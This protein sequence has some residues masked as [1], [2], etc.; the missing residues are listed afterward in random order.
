MDMTKP[1]DLLFKEEV[2]IEDFKSLYPEQDGRSLRRT[3]NYHMGVLEKVGL[4][5]KVE[6]GRWKVRADTIRAIEEFERL[7]EKFGYEGDLFEFI[8]EIFRKTKDL[9]KEKTVIEVLA[10]DYGV[11]EEALMEFIE[12]FLDN[13]EW[14]NEEDLRVFLKDFTKGLWVR[15]EPKTYANFKNLNRQELMELR[16]KGLTEEEAVIVLLNSLLQKTPLSLKLWDRV[17][18]DSTNGIVGWVEDRLTER[19]GLK[20]VELVPVN[21]TLY[22]N[23]QEEICQLIDSQREAMKNKLAKRLNDAVEKTLREAKEINRKKKVKR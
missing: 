18:E 23:M 16:A 17:E 9:L 8:T 6:S 13:V 15:I 1:K 10:E 4:A 22:D 12:G 3:A 21:K 2:T 20:G 5:K 7:R 19:N 11:S 14:K